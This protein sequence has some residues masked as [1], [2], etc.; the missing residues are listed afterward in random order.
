MDVFRWQDVKGNMAAFEA[1]MASD[2]FDAA[3]SLAEDEFSILSRFSACASTM[4]ASV[5]QNVRDEII[6]KVAPLAGNTW[7]TQD[8]QRLWSFAATT[9]PQRLQYLKLL[10]GYMHSA[11]ELRI[12][13]RFFEKLGALPGRA[14]A[15]RMCLT[16]E[17]ITSEQAHQEKDLWVRGGVTR[18]IS[19]CRTQPHIL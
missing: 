7:T 14:Q 12:S 17:Q 11:R 13:P 2:N 10:M 5:G 19:I 6:A 18:A 1:L 3:F 4:T 9:E 16:V 15:L 8:L